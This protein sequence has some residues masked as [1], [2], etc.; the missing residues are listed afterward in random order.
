MEKIQNLQERIEEKAK[1]KLGN[2]LLAFYE[3]VKSNKLL[4]NNNNLKGG[5]P[6]IK[7][8]DTENGYNGHESADLSDML[9]TIVDTKGVSRPFGRLA[10]KMFE[11]WLP[12]YIN[13]EME[14]FLSKIEEIEKGVNYLLDKEL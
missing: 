2:D 8:M 6:E 14:T 11:Y 12:F 1:K 13:A 3:M 7:V 4:Q 5:Y 10:T 9:H